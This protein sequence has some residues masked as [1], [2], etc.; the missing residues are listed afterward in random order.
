M[1]DYF[2]NFSLVLLLKDETQKQ[3]ALDLHKEAVALRNGELI[4]KSFPATLKP[5]LP[6]WFFDT[7]ENDEGVWLHSQYGGIEAVC[8]FIQH[9]L[10]KFNR[11]GIVTFAWSHDCTKPKIDAY[12]GGAAIVTAAKVK[13]M[14]TADWIR[15]NNPDKPH[16]R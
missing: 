1:A 13:T 11:A 12:G 16:K 5:H 9:L 8:A 14:D 7:E 4:P 2:T 15:A 6:D 3:Y 10:Q